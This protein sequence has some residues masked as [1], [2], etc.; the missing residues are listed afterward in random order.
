M[1][2]VA[3]FARPIGA[4]LFAV[5]SDRLPWNPLVVDAIQGHRFRGDERSLRRV[6]CTESAGGILATSAV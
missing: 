4:V 5:P 1:P 6:G 2:A 3:G